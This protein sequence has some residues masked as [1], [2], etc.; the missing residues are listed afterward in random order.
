[1]SSAEIISFEGPQELGAPS[2]KLPALFLADTKTPERFWEFA[3][4]VRNKNT[5]RAYF[6]RLNTRPQRQLRLHRL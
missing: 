6:M 5:R 3:A 4:N 2:A 1:V